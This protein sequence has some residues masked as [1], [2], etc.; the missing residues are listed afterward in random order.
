MKTYATQPRAEPVAAK[1]C[2][3]CGRQDAKELWNL[4]DFEFKRC[5]S[6]GL[7]RQEPQ[8]LA[9]AVLSR[10]GKEY[11]EYEVPRQFMYRDL[12][13]LGLEDIGFEDACVDYFAKAK[14]EGRSPKI[15]DVGCATGALLAELKSRGWSTV[16]VEACEP[17]AAYARE[18]FGLD[19]RYTTLGDAKFE[20]AS[21]EA[22]HASHL[23]EHLNDP[24]DFLDEVARVLVP[25]GILALTTPNAD[26]LQARILGP[27][28]RSAIYDHLYLFS[29]RTLERLLE[30]KGFRLERVSTWGG[31][32]LGQKPEFLKAPLDRVAKAFG[33]GD[34]MALL[35]RR[36]P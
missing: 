6:C 19:A 18:H 31:W 3:I 5:P 20:T 12:E 24:A 8:S 36:L 30:K 4:G 16:G 9:S 25:D 35:A 10:Y 14:A 33:F 2:P 13:L 26:G 23:I 21:F 1:P 7:I 27:R 32:A 17:A 11:L 28:W 22:V 34:V 29:L 15:L